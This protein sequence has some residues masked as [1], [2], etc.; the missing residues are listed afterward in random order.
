MHI[1][2]MVFPF[3]SVQTFG[4]LV[5]FNPHL[6]VLAADGAFLLAEGFRRARRGN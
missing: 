3:P 6:R 5:N 4:A 2:I 1:L